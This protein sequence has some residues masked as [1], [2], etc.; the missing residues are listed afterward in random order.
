VR[1]CLAPLWKKEKKK[2][3]GVDNSNPNSGRTTRCGQPR[4]FS[5]GTKKRG[6]QKKSAAQEG[7]NLTPLAGGFLLPL[8]APHPVSFQ[9]D[10]VRI[11]QPLFPL[12]REQAQ[13]PPILLLSAAQLGRKFEINF[14]AQLSGQGVKLF[15][16]DTAEAE[17]GGN[18]KK[19]CTTSGQRAS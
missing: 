12:T 7:E 4:N 3:R 5:S 13:P 14:S 2:I 19:S 18:E 6:A 16:K 15:Q 17:S 1:F 10:V 11:T 8:L 9:Q